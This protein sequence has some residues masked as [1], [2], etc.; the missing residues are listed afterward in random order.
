VLNPW[1]FWKARAT[2]GLKREAAPPLIVANDSALPK[3]FTPEEAA[4]AAILAGSAPEGL[5]TFSL[6]FER[7]AG[8]R[9]LPK[10]LTVTELLISECPN[11]HGLPEKLWAGNIVVRDCPAF[12]DIPSSV[13]SRSLEVVHGS[14]DLVLG[15]GASIGWL[16]LIGYSGNLEFGN[17]LHCGSLVWNQSPIERLPDGIRVSGTLDLSNSPHL[18]ELP[19]QMCLGEL[20]LRECSRLERLPDR[21]EAWTLDIS[22][23]TRLQWQE[24]A[25]VEVSELNISDCPQIATLPSWL[26]VKESLDVANTSLT[27]LPEEMLKCRLLWRGVKVDARIAFHPEQIEVE[28]VFAQRNAEVRRV[29]LERMGWERF[30]CEAKPKM[31]DRDFDPGGERRL[32]KV[33]FQDREDVQVLCISCPST[34]RRYF[35][36]VP[37][38]VTTC[39]QAAAWMAGFD[40]PKQYEPVVET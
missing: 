22:G 16:R 17:R 12:Q 35:I 8:L 32:L 6:S 31:R 23:C 13:W 24:D 18:A 28:E 25:F 38:Y 27:E 29:I 11:F 7:E 39:H 14:R 2:A 37:P 36:Q 10:G 34:N 1:N 4:R 15:E 9:A 3:G 40:D 30:I 19:R 5:R 21:L 26:I 33:S 20:V